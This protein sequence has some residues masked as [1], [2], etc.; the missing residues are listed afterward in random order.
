LDATLSRTPINAGPYLR[1]GLTLSQT[2]TKVDK[3]SPAQIEF[4]AGLS[5]LVN[6][7]GF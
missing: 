6:L 3:K 1:Q 5:Y 2:L 7:T 4:L